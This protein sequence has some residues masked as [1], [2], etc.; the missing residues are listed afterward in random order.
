M[1]AG[2]VKLYLT[3]PLVWHLMAPLADGIALKT[4]HVIVQELEQT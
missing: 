2:E 4:W 3:L 1:S